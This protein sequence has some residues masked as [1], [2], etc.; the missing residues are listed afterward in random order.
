MND[1]FAI[2]LSVPGVLFLAFTSAI[3][4]T[5]FLYPLF[6][7][8]ANGIEK[9]LAGIFRSPRESEKIAGKFPDRLPAVTVVIAA[10]NEEKDIL[11]KIHDTMK[12]DYPPGFLEIIVASDCSTDRTDDIVKSLSGTRCPVRL[13]RGEVRMGKTGVQNLAVKN[14][15]GDI[16]L[17]TDATT[18]LEPDLLKHI[19][20]HFANPGVGAVSA[21]YY[22]TSDIDTA[23]SMGQKL[24]WGYERILRI[25]ESRLG[26]SIGL[27]GCCYAVRKSAYEPI[28]PH[29]ISDFSTPLVLRLK[30]FRSVYEPGAVAYEE[31]NLDVD[32]EKRMRV[33][34]ISR[35]LQSLWNYRHA[36]NPFRFGMFSVQLFIHKI[37]R[38]LV[39]FLAMGALASNLFLLG[40]GL[41]RLM[42]LAQ[43]VFYALGTLPWILEKARA[44]RIVSLPHYF[45][46]A[47]VSVILAL[48]DFLKGEK[49]V[50]WNPQRK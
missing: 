4:L 13:V 30:G 7:V 12:L 15:S 17:F 37:L 24:Y 27:S 22:Y 20:P 11:D 43:A 45:V 34:I 46:L 25:M 38:Y 35:T 5:Y 14:A 29:L 10:H 26:G 28:P 42:F 32:K 3:L 2:F 49:Y 21:H 9:I 41:G 31:P 48:V 44:S 8:A 16:L 40:T 23:T 19:V 47:N 1:G 6:L 50:I 39:P 18:K 36:L 33:R